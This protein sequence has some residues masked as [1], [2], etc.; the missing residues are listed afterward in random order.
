MPRMRYIH[1]VG[2]TA[3]RG[4]EGKALTLLLDQEESL[5]LGDLVEGAL[6]G[7][8]AFRGGVV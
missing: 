1:R 8:E 5:L 2:R 4:K 7:V 3:R 6:E